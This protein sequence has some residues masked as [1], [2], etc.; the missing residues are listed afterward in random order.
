MPDMKKKSYRTAATM[1]AGVL[2]MA[3]FGVGN[4]QGDDRPSAPRSERGL[5]PVTWPTPRTHTRCRGMPAGTSSGP[6]T[7]PDR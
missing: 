6:G 7:T 1:L 3:L 2:V 4:V 5:K